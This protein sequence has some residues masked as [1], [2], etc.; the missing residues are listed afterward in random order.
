M[1]QELYSSRCKIDDGLMLT[2]CTKSMEWKSLI[3]SLHFD[4][5][6]FDHLT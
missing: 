4:Y 1:D 6:I 2:F 5:Y 3:D